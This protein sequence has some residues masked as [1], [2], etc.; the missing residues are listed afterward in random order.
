MTVR[1]G[2]PPKSPATETTAETVVVKRLQDYP[3]H[4]RE[5]ADK[6]EGEALF[7]LGH[8]CGLP[9]SSMLLMST[10]KLRQQIK[11][12]QTNRYEVA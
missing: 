10:A 7:E 4:E 11:L 5:N 12:A 3:R 2:R 6:V 1:R 8:R 9:R